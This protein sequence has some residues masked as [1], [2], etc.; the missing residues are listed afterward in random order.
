MVDREVTQTSKNDS[1]DI[2]A[3]CNPSALWSPRSKEDV[4]RDIDSKDY[5]YHVNWP[6]K[7]TEIQVVEG[8]TGKYLRTDRDGTTRNN[9][10]DLPDC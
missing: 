5:T 8:K 2:T 1:G 6:G 7:R 9:L 4:I 10:F 3:L